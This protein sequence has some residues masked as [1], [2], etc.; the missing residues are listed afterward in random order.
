MSESR[1]ALHPLLTSYDLELLRVLAGDFVLLTRQQICQ[2]FPDRSVRNT[3]YRLHKLIESGYVSRRFYPSVSLTPKVPLYYLG[4]KAAEALGF[5]PDAPE[6]LARRK[7]ALQLRDGAIP[8]F[9]LVNSVHIKFLTA[10]RDYPDYE[11]H[12]WIHQYDSL[13]RILNDH[14]FPLRP[15][16]YAEFSKDSYTVRVFLE[17]DRGTERGPA[18]RNKLTEYHQY[19]LSGLFQ[20]HFSAPNFRVLFITNTDRRLRHLV[21]HMTHYESD[22]FWTTT[23]RCFFDHPL[24]HPCWSLPRSDVLNSIAMPL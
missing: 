3:N 2:L 19:A 24:F 12:S 7:Q 10:T 20:E 6:I 9:L 4:T 13:W 15:D 1:N 22:I 21:R 8:H 17:L 14:A 18:I 23:T 5:Q 16:A 11:L